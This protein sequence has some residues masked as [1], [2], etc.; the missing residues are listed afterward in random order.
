MQWLK[1]GQTVAQ[2]VVFSLDSFQ[3]GWLFRFKDTA[4]GRVFRG[5]MW[6]KTHTKKTFTGK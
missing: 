1:W 2:E 6:E 5:D 3:K 4:V